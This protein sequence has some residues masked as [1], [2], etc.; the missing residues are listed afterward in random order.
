MP[1]SLLTQFES[2]SLKEIS[3]VSLLNRIDSKYIITK[4]QLKS[5]LTSLI[6][7]HDIV[8]ID[9]ARILPYHT[10]YFDT[11]EYS[12]YRAHHNGS[13]NRYKYRTRK[14]V[15]SNLVFNEI[16]RK[17]NTGKTFKS[18]IERSQFYN[19][20][21]DRFTK[22]SNE[23]SA[24]LSHHYLPQ[25]YVDYNRITLVDKKLTERLTIDLDLTLYDN[26][27]NRKFENVV[28]VE[29]KRERGV[30]NSH[31]SNALNDLRVRPRGFSKYCIGMALIKKN[32][33]KNLFKEKIRFLEKL[34]ENV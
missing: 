7:T 19:E 22:F 3:K 4:P 33:K 26:S 9:N 23:N 1:D 18:R 31:S 27:Q 5:L 30:R 34:E 21:D 2:K 16:K 14:Y 8:E 28:I 32:I 12:C 20:I 24:K 11:A 6:P 17:N 15:S 13:L 29:S 10:L 25:L